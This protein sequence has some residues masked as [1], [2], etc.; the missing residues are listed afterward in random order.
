MTTIHTHA[1][2]TPPPPPPLPSMAAPQPRAVTALPRAAASSGSAPLRGDNARLI[3][4]GLFVAG[5]ILLPVG[6]IVICLGWYGIANTPYQYDQLV[7]IVSGGLLGLGITFVGG[8][9]YFGA[10]IARVGADLK[11]ADKRLSDTLLVL[12]DSITHAVAGTQAV[13]AGPQRD[14]RSV[15]VVAGNSTT[16]HRADCQLLEGRN[17]L[18]PAGPASG[19]TACRLCRPEE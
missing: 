10:W 16:V 1:D 5:A 4:V 9:L 3:Q 18:T 17:D 11:D 2:S 15:L 13:S 14:A 8:F 12:A 19:L 7:Y 6:I